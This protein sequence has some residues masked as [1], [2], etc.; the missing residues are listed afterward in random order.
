MFDIAYALG[1]PG[2]AGSGQ[3][4]GF[5][6]FLPLIVIFAIFYFLLI[7][8][9]QR[10]VKKHRDFLS[11]LEKGKLAVTSGGLHGKITGLTESIATLEIASGVKV[12]VSRDQISGY[13]ELKSAKE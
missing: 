3:Q 4:G 6:A 11:N 1:A 7:L 2:N 10:K 9:Q 12:K 5:M 8:P 13:T